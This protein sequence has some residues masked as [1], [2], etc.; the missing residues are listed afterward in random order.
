MQLNQTIEYAKT[1]V[2]NLITS[3]KLKNRKQESCHSLVKK[4]DTVEQVNSVT[5]DISHVSLCVKASPKPNFKQGAENTSKDSKDSNRPD[6][7]CP[8]DDCPIRNKQAL[9]KADRGRKLSPRE[10]EDKDAKTC[11]DNNE[12][13][14]EDEKGKN[15]KGKKN[16]KD[17]KK[18]KPEN[19]PKR[20]SVKGKKTKLSSSAS[21]IADSA[22]TNCCACCGLLAEYFKEVLRLFNCEEDTRI[23]D[24][25][26]EMLDVAGCICNDCLNL[27]LKLL[28]C[29]CRFKS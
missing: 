19:R 2:K 16:A 1:T 10:G 15:K 5:S 26:C 21:I 6:D 7:C 18:A 27:L 8:A 9:G 22:Q 11:Y 28:S 23:S 14:E 24:V 25:F 12:K 20:K 4:N 29:V 3:I 13:D 17:S